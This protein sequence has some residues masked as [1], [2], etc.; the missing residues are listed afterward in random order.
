MAGWSG[1]L[2]TH[3]Y[4]IMR[5]YRLDACPEAILVVCP[6]VLLLDPGT[7]KASAVSWYDVP[8]FFFYFVLKWFCAAL[9][10]MVPQ[11]FPRVRVFIKNVPEGGS[12]MVKCKIE[13]MISNSLV[14]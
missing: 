2:R 10:G 5:I 14:F 13:L 6:D 8:P 3:A 4:V 1:H 11:L 7:V 12:S 9:F